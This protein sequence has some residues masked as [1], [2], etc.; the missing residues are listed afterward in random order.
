MADSEQAAVEMAS[1]KNDEERAGDSG[2]AVQGQSVIP[3]PKQIRV[4]VTFNLEIFRCIGLSAGIVLLLIGTIVTNAA[5][6]FPA[7]GDEG[8]NGKFNA[9]AT[10]IYALFHFNHT[11]TVLDFNPSKSVSALVV[12]LNSVPMCLFVVLSYLRIRQDYAQGQVNKALYVFSAICT[13]YNFLAYLYFYMVFVNSPYD[14]SS[15]IAHYLPYMFYQIALMLTAFEQCFYVL[16]KN[17]IPFNASPLLV[18]IYL[19]L[20]VAVC[21]FYTIFVWSFLADAPIID[22]TKTGPR[23][24]AVFIMFTFDVMAVIFPAFMA[25][26]HCYYTDKFKQRSYLA[27]YDQDEVQ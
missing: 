1:S 26:Y 6:V 23:S 16:Q 18:K 13:P 7:K 2:S 3:L 14:K 22:T 21:L 17:L 12:M 24:F 11:C 4:G 9:E 15:F 27:F 19:A 10:Y 20:L 5:V 8:Y 25:G